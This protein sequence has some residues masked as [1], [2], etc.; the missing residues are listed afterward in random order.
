MARGPKWL[1]PPILLSTKEEGGQAGLSVTSVW[2]KRAKE[3]MEDDLQ[4]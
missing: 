1:G 4:L 2:E 3:E